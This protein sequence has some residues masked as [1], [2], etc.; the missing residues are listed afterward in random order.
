MYNK[1]EDLGTTPT[2]CHLFRKPNQAG[3]YTYY[4]DE[5]G[6]GVVVWDTALVNESTLLTAIVCEHHRKYVQHAIDNN[7]TPNPRIEPETD[8]MA[9]AGESFVPRDVSSK[10]ECAHTDVEY[11]GSQHVG[12][13]KPESGIE[14][15]TSLWCKVC[16]AS[17]Q[18]PTYRFDEDI[19]WTK[20][21]KG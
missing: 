7:W 14:V 12:R 17:G 8:R 4:S 3:G 1:T 21:K 13:L 10:K 15:I 6:G 19:M 11:L 16:G 20:P 2:G 5:I 18:R 9:A